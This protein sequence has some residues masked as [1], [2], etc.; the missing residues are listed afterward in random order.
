M[1]AHSA[2]P[3]HELLLLALVVV[4]LIRPVRILAS[5]EGADE[6]RHLVAKSELQGPLLV[7]ATAYNS[8]V[9]QTEGDPE[10][11]AWGDRLVPGVNSVAVSTDLVELG[12]KRGARVRI[13]GLRGEFLVLDRMPP[14]WTRRIDIHMGENVDAAKRWGRRDVRIYWQAP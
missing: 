10:I 8:V 7:E 13:E 11:G 9:G 1:G 14:Q 4:V 12:M 2:K 3:L 6:R 5:G